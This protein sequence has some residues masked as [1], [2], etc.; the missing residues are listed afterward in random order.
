VPELRLQPKSALRDVHLIDAAAAA[1][2][3]RTDV[4]LA[5][6]TPRRAMRKMCADRL[7]AVYDLDAPARAKFVQHAGLML[8]W[9]GPDSW[10]MVAGERRD[11]ES[12]LTAVVGDS[13]AIVD[14]SDTRVVLRL[15]GR[16]ARALLAK[17]VS[18][19]FDPR[20]FGVGDTAITILAHIVVQVWQID[21]S[22][23]FDVAVPQATIG[24][25]MQFFEISAAQFGAS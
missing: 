6:I 3:E 9:A 17:G 7:K 2:S 13:A 19:D 18:I 24:D 5:L 16:K 15:S 12:E 20:A 1:V 8:S 11:L 23:T 14:L 21:Q 10:L 22:S 25:I 4:S